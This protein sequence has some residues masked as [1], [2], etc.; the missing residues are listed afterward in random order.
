MVIIGISNYFYTTLN[1][2][3]VDDKNIIKYLRAGSVIF[4]L[5]H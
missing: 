3:T 4:F 1:N 5:G 2:M